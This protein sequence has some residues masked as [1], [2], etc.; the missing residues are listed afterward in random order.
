[1]LD[2]P[3]FGAALWRV[4]DQTG[5]R[6][7]WQ[8][9]VLW[10][11]SKFNPS[12]CN[13]IGCCGLNQFCRSA[14]STYVHVPVEEYRTWSASRQLAGPILEYWQEALRYGPIRSGTKLMLAQLG[15]GLISRSSLD[16]VVFSA[17][18]VE[19]AGNSSFDRAG[20]GYIT[21]RDIANAVS[22]NAKQQ[23]VCDALA[24]A[25]SMRPNERPSD[26]VYGLD[27]PGHT[28]EFACPTPSPSLRLPIEGVRS[29]RTASF[30][31]ILTLAVAAGYG[32]HAARTRWG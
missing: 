19:Y 26:P 12:I 1:M 11:E 6:P 3:A 7:E 16:S 15:H 30:L 5:I 17:P 28:V 13:S 22:G 10:L 9:P 32:A 2:W 14:Y 31:G 27:Y 23:A 20:K 21:V 4:S 24:L 18:S 29:G 8:L 25:Y